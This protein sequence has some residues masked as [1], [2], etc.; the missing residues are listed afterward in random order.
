[1][2]DLP[3]NAMDLAQGWVLS[4]FLIYI[5]VFLVALVLNFNF[6]TLLVGMIYL[7]PLIPLGLTAENVTRFLVVS[8][9]NMVFGIIELVIFVI[10]VRAADITFDRDY[11]KQLLGHVLPIAVAL[12]GLSFYARAST[13]P[14]GGWELVGIVLLFFFGSIMRVLAVHQLGALGFKFDIVFREQQKLMTRK[15]YSLMRHPSYTAMMAVVLA[16][17][18]NTHSWMA[19]A[20]GLVCAW[21]GF[22]YRIHHE[23]KALHSQFGEDYLEYK[24]RTGMW[25]PFPRRARWGRS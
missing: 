25:F 19:G 12:I 1:M 15:L 8:C 14:V 16:Y 3:F 22:Q 21:F 7:L 18:L 11:I 5:A 4:N 9:Q 17:A 24:S 2:A 13:L 23:E 20:L 6:N 10:T